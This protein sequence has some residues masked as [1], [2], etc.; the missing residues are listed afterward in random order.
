MASKS[1]RAMS[2]AQIAAHL[3]DKFD[4]TKKTGAAVLEE[5]A[6]LAY[7]EAKKASPSPASASSWS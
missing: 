1:A 5:I 3:A 6:K 7:K 2:K 4:L